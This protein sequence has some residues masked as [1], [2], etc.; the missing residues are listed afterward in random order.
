LETPNIFRAAGV[1]LPWLMTCLIGSFMYTVIYL[2]YQ[3][4]FS[5][6]VW[7]SILMF[8]PAIAAMGGNSGLQ[9]STIVVRGLATGDLAALKITQVLLREMRIAL[10]IACVCGIAAGALS[11][12]VLHI[13][14]EGGTQALEAGTAAALSSREASLLGLAVG[15]AMFCGIMVATSVGL[16]L[17]FA[18][19]RLGIDPAIS[20]GPFVTTANDSLGCL[21]YFSIALGLIHSLG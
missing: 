21:A 5:A 11:S 12:V 4:H 13:R 8:V 6:E 15:L 3:T 19:R 1:R 17:P 10:I 9:T 2:F 16:L 18:F 20:S 14:S 7:T